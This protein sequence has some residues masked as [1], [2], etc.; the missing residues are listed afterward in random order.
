MLFFWIILYNLFIYP[1][2]YLTAL[3]A[4]FFNTKIRAGFIGKFYS[5]E[6][7]KSYFSFKE[8]LNKVYWFHVSS[9]GEFYQIAPL[10]SILKEKNPQ[11]TRIVS[12]SSPSGYNN[13][14][15]EL[16]HLKFYLPFDFIWTII[17]VFKI[18]KPTKIIF[19]SYDLW[20][21]LLFLS[22]Y[23][24]IPTI[25]SSL[26]IPSSS[27]KNNL[28]LKS[29]YQSLY[30]LFHS[31]FTI[32][33]NDEVRLQNFLINLERL[34][35]ICALGNPRFDF[36]KDHF[37]HKNVNIPKID[38]LERKNTIIIASSH[39][40]DDKVVVPAL[41]K[42][43]GL[44]PD[45]NILYV[46]HDLDTIP[47]EKIKTQFNKEGIESVLHTGNH[48]EIPDEKVVII[49]SIGLL[50][51]L[52]WISK[53]SYVGGG[54]STGVH[55]VMEPALAKLPLIFGPKHKNAPEAE[56]LIKNQGG[57]LIQN[58]NDFFLIM[59][60]LIKDNKK[61]K[62]AS[63]RSRDIIESNLGASKKII[64]KIIDV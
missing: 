41:I 3:F 32:T 46:P 23:Y 15:G 13:V 14:K 5:I 37:E 33:P 9:L 61:I 44:Y 40:E 8:K 56:Q 18:I 60:K 35:E 39:L 7:L 48:E 36:V 26:R 2:L 10:L 51:N 58:S 20:P 11:I 30:G 59:D 52:Y 29:F 16:Y 54:F 31:I 25:L 50:A 22:K 53:I 27:K 38:I 64:K 34:P 12:F 19:S 21:N 45:W 47:I 49:R 24:N 4:S 17:N 63:E 6:I 28:I 1:L 42:V 43:L 57:F 55:N 62:D